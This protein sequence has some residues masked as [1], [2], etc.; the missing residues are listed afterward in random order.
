[1]TILFLISSEG[2]YGME[3][4]LVGL[5]QQLSQQGCQC[6]VGVFCDK[7][8]R[9]TEVADEATRRGLTVELVEC[10]GKWDWSS[11]RRVRQ[12][13]GKYNVEVLH[14]HGYKADMYAYAASWRSRVVL[15]ATSH[16]WPNKRLLMRAYAALDRLVLRR[17]DRVVV[18]SDAVADILGRWG[19]SPTKVCT[20]LNGV[21]LARFQRAS[22]TLRGELNLT[23]EPLVG[24]VGRMV[25]D[26][27]GALLLRAA[28]QVLA[29]Y[30]KTKFVF[31]GDGPAR[32]EWETLAA[33]LRIQSSTI[34]TGTRGDMP[35]VYAS[36][37]MLVLPSLIEAQ[38]MCLLEAMA[39][40]NA[41]IATRVGAIPKM[42][43][44]GKTGVLLER[45]DVAGL[46]A[47][48]VRLLSDS[49]LRRRLGESARAHAAQHFSAEAMAKNYLANYQDLLRQRQRGNTR[50]PVCELG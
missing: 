28:D 39:A 48:I 5:A 44:S 37:D 45:G 20:I 12:L 34:F 14:P 3:N 26:K 15:L 43:Q 10:R 6:V 32:K 41:V 21:D 17:F 47:A 33:Q 13:I 27:G 9:H 8:R 16:N 19:V 7:R 49:D 2:Y 30:P 40:G 23:N 24:F 29:V 42:I 36:F 38:P 35:E 46:S 31:V 25:S 1:V 18:V 4:M 22:A 50:H 11:V